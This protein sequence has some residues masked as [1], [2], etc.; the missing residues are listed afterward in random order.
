MIK[1]K[2]LKLAREVLAMLSTKELRDAQG[3]I[4]SAA[5]AACE[6]SG[7]RPCPTKAGVCG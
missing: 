3:G 7:I 6:P 4:D 5:P 1:A 2:K